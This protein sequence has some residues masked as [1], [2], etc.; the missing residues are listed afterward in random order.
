MNLSLGVTCEYIEAF[1]NGE[2]HHGF[3]RRSNDSEVARYNDLAHVFN[4]TTLKNN[5]LFHRYQRVQ[6]GDRREA[7]VVNPIKFRDDLFDIEYMGE[8]L[9]KVP[10]GNG[11]LTIRRVIV[12]KSA[13]RRPY[14]PTEMPS[15]LN[16]QYSTVAERGEFK[17]VILLQSGIS[18]KQRLQT[19]FK[20][21][22]SRLLEMPCIPE[23]FCDGYRH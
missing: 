2:I 18:A 14:I 13:F 21:N 8:F 15:I 7:P 1:K 9:D 10:H 19:K 5:R 4:T 11:L 20:Y 16:M 17:E 3:F 12:D 23:D 22:F 6:E